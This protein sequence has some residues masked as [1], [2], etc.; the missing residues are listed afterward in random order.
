MTPDASISILVNK[1]QVMGYSDSSI[2]S[3]ESIATTSPEQ[4]VTFSNMPAPN[5]R[6]PASI[7]DE[8]RRACRCIEMLRFSLQEG[9]DDSERATVFHV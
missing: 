8:L 4:K 5:D 7:C 1:K 9:R 3:T 2:S 6:I